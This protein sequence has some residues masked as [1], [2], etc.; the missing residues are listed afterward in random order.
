MIA[1]SDVLDGRLARALDTTSPLGRAFDHAADITFILTALG[2]YAR[3]GDLPWAAPAAVAV[4]FAVYVVDSWFGRP[5][6][7]TTPSAANWLGHLGG[8]CNYVVVGI[9]VGNET[10]G[11]HLLPSRLVYALGAGVTFYSLAAILT[12][13]LA[14]LERPIRTATARRAED[15][16]RPAALE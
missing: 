15:Q 16:P 10:V 5:R 14:V 2:A 1:A 4:A 13:S 9:L 11:L 8:V 7:S 12:R 6:S 3:R